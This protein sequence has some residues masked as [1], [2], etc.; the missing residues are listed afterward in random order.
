MYIYIFCCYVQP[1]TSRAADRCCGQSS[2]RIRRVVNSKIDGLEQGI[3]RNFPWNL[4]Q[5]LVQGNKWLNFTIQYINN[6]HSGIPSLF[7]LFS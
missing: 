4:G 3:G 6:E 5:K 7:L 1:S 2:V